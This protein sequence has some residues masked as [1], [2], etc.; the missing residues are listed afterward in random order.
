MQ[1]SDHL[2][3]AV[4]S[5]GLTAAKFDQFPRTD[6]EAWASAYFPADNLERTDHPVSC[7]LSVEARGL[8]AAFNAGRSFERAQVQ[9]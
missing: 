1:D 4:P 7:Y 3:T 6:F 5:R 9:A 2:A 8:Y